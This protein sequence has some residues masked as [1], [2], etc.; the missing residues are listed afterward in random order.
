MKKLLLIVSIIFLSNCVFSQWTHLGLE[1]AELQM[2]ENNIGY[3]FI[4]TPGPSPAGGITYEVKMTHNDWVGETIIATGGGGDYG[5]CPVSNLYFKN[6]S[7][8]LICK[9]YQGVYNFQKTND[10]G[11]N[12]SSFASI[13]TF[14]PENM[15]LVNDSIGYISGNSYGANHGL[16]YK[17]TPTASIKL[18]E[19]DT[20][21]FASGNIEFLDANTG[22]IIMT[23]SNQH[24]HLFKTNNSGGNW[25][26]LF[27]DTNNV[28]TSIS[29]PDNLIGYMSSTNGKI[30]KTI[31]GGNNWLELLSP[32]TKNVNSI[33]FINDSIGYIVCDEG[34][35]YITNNGALSWISE[36]SGTLSKLIDIQMVDINNAY[37]I[38][39]NGVLLKNSNVLSTESSTELYTSQITIYPNPSSDFISISLPNNLEAKSVRVFDNS[40]KHLLTGTNNTIDISNLASGIYIVKIMLDHK[41]FTSRFIKQ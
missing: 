11:L 15:I 38:D 25:N 23:D 8:G 14:I 32:T 29:F 2:I 40:G 20:L 37:C 3:K 9:G 16:L 31:D 39:E 18:F 6:I 1:G 34:E 28:L 5:C 35:I 30:Y 4:N 33:D 21:F 10:S 7:E 24:S 27:S 13:I 26:H 41:V 19:N 36:P 22:F 12:W 17:L